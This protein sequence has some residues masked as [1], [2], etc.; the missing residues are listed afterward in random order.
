MFRGLVFAGLLAL[1][2]SFAW[3]QQPCS[4]DARHVVDELYRHML[5]R[6]A[7]AGSQGSVDRLNQRITVRELVRQIAQSTEHT[8][9]FVHPS[10]SRNTNRDAA[11]PLHRHVLAPRP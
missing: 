9:R 1:A 3:A 7:D 8:Q 10:G 5:E 4:T 11:R 6:T 2:P